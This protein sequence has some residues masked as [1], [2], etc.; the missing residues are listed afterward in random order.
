MKMTDDTIVTMATVFAFPAK[1]Q[2]GLI[3]RTVDVLDGKS[4]ERSLGEPY[5][6]RTADRMARRMAVA[7]I[8]CLT[9]AREVAAFRRAV[10]DESFRRLLDKIGQRVAK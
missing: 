9:I 10:E 8:D 6:Q 4:G 5:L 7:G 3:R 2:T 1:R